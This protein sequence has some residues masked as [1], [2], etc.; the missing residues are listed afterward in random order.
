MQQQYT[1]IVIVQSTGW[2]WTW[3]FSGFLAKQMRAL[4]LCLLN[5]VSTYLRIWVAFFCLFFK[6]GR[7][8]FFLVVDFS[9]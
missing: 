9:L 6:G 7:D 3:L 5:E 2:H 1:N 4:F 8:G